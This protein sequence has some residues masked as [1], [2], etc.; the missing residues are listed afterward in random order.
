MTLSLSGG[1]LGRKLGTPFSTRRTFKPRK[2]SVKL[3]LETQNHAM[4]FPCSPKT[5][6][7][8]PE[9]P[10]GA[11]HKAS[12]VTT[13]PVCVWLREPLTSEPSSSR[14]HPTPTCLQVLLPTSAQVFSMVATRYANSVVTN[15]QAS[16]G[17]E[18]LRTRAHSTLDYLR[19][20]TGRCESHFHTYK[21]WLA[22]LPTL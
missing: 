7:S 17:T 19:V 9:S 12:D 4:S 13:R 22:I 2:P 21:T 6:L 15:L 3:T 10:L 5:P 8:M 1:E 14:G 11:P 18:G 20:V 16:T